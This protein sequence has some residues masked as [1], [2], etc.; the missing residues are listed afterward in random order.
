MQNENEKVVNSNKNFLRTTI[1]DIVIKLDGKSY[2]LKDL[3]KNFL[4]SGIER[5]VFIDPRNSKRVI[6][7]SMR[8]YCK[9]TREESRYF[10]FLKS[11]KVPFTHLPKYYGYFEGENYIGLC[12]ELL[13]NEDGSRPKPMIEWCR[14]DPSQAEDLLVELF[15]FLYRYNVLSRDSTLDSNIV[16]VENHKTF[17]YR[18][19]LIDGLYCGAR[20]PLNKYVKFFGRG[21]IKRQFY[22]NVAWVFSSPDDVWARIVAKAREKN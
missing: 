4:G 22:R 2:A 17:G 7:I 18:C 20:I 19:K 21:S 1:P 6:K 10:S 16:V 3:K 13:L 5:F 9:Q 15:A 11:R 14:K 8:S 12:Q